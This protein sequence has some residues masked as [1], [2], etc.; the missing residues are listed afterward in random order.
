MFLVRPTLPA[1][2]EARV[3]L[4]DVGQGLAVVVQTAGHT[5]V[6]DTGARLSARFD[7]GRAVVVPFL[8]HEGVT[9]VDTLIVS[10]G[11]NDHIGGSASLLA[12]LPVTRVLSSVPE[13]L[14]NA[15]ACVSGQT[16]EWDGV[17]FTMLHPEAGTRLEGN[18]RCCVLRVESRFGQALLPGDIAAKAE[19]ELMLR[20][21]DQL[22]ADILVVPHH[23]SK[24]SST[25]TF[26]DTVRPRVALLPVGYRNRYHHPHPMVVARYR[27]R[28]IALEDSATA[29]AI[30]VELGNQG[31]QRN[32]YR[33][34]QRRYWQGE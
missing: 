17:R 23:G 8:R 25:E 22:R 2:G 33:E 15:E 7:A 20:A 27:E 1:P 5:L 29:G 21:E 26:L 30:T 19:R 4:L 32:R 13:R 14:A 11:D 10:H 28:D 18:N 3:T 9:R 16:W 34:S 12:A 31:L 6:Y 24:T